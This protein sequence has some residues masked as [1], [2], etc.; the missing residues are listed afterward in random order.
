[1]LSLY[2]LPAL[3]RIPT[4][5]LRAFRNVLSFALNETPAKNEPIGIALVKQAGISFWEVGSKANFIRVRSSTK[6]SYREKSN[7]PSTLQDIS[8]PS[9]VNL[10]RTGPSICV[11]DTDQYRVLDLQ[12]LSVTPI[13]DIS[14]VKHFK[15]LPII[16]VAQPDEYLC[17]ACTYVS[18]DMLQKDGIGI[19]FNGRGDPTDAPVEWKGMPESV[20]IDSNHIITLFNDLFSPTA[21]AFVKVQRRGEQGY[22]QSLDVPS[23]RP[24]DFVRSLTLSRFGFPVPTNSRQE[25]LLMKRIPLFEQPVKQ[26]EASR[27]KNETE[28]FEEPAGSGLTPPPTPKAP[29]QSQTA[30]RS[31]G[32]GKGTAG[33]NNGYKDSND[34]DLAQTVSNLPTAAVLIV[35]SRSVHALLPSNLL[36]QIESLLKDGRTKDAGSFL[37]Q[38]YSK[39]GKEEH[40]VC[41]SPLEIY[42]ARMIYLSILGSRLPLLEYSDWNLLLTSDA[43]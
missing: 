43:L 8:L 28:G 5:S 24:D 12:A 26:P 15:I 6:L 27:R 20:C 41:H 38:A 39:Y 33:S 7:K 35:T 19:F 36:S 18:D 37:S 3:Q 17:V 10:K 21:R 40:L 22:L 11:A 13:H 9:V 31:R 34:Q 42:K 2:S 30:Q 23:G 16:E 14:L 4:D 25:K 29:S 1:V 32:Q